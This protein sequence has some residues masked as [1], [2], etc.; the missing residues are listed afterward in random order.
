MAPKKIKIFIVDDHDLFRE[1]VNLLISG[2]NIAEI[3]AEAVN[4]E[5]FLEKIGSVEPDIVLMDIAM[6]VMDGIEATRLAHEKYPELKIIALTMFGDEKYYY[7]MLQSGVKGFI[8]KSSGIGE[9]LKG[10]TDVYN[11]KSYFSNELLANLIEGFKAQ[12]NKEAKI[13]A[14]NS[15]H[16][17]AREVEVLKLIA[18]GSSNEEI[19]QKLHVSTTTIRTHRARIL[20]KTG[21]NNTASLVFYAIKNKFVAL[22]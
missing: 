2:S 10:I 16:L 20:S 11:N 7:Q 8:L 17:S 12:L 13:T 14:N 19:S 21:C 1:G 9:L 4:G 15:Q 3:V 22:N 18:I 5:E 6:P